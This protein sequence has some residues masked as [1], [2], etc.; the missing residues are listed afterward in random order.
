MKR[1]KS[2]KNKNF[3]SAES[4]WCGDKIGKLVIALSSTTTTH[5]H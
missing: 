2:K 5:S 4:R 1:F 3:V